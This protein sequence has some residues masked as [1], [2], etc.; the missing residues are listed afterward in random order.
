MRYLELKIYHDGDGITVLIWAADRSRAEVMKVLIESPH[1][2]VNIKGDGYTALIIAAR[3][4]EERRWR[5][6]ET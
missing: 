6:D 4:G 2:D 5:G 1:N 3:S